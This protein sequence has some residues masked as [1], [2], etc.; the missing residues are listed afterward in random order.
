MIRECVE[1]GDEFDDASNEKRRAGGK[2]CHCPECSEE[3]VVRYVGVHNA[4][5]KQAGCTVV[6]LDSDEDARAFVDDWK[7]CSGSLASASRRASPKFSF[8][9]VHENLP[10]INHK[11]RD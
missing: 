11:G 1:C 2:I 4:A 8:R 5:G 3:T 10:S 6:A 9:T 7:R